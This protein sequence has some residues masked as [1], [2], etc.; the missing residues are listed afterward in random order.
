MILDSISQ[1]NLELINTLRD[2]KK[3]GTLLGILD[4]TVTPMAG[5][6]LKQWI[7]SPLIVKKDI[8]SRHN[9]IE[10]FIENKTTLYSLREILHEIKDLERIIA[11]LNCGSGNPR[12]MLSLKASCYAFP[13]IKQTIS[14][15]SDPLIVLLAK[16]IDEMEELATLLESAIRE[17]APIMIREGNIIKEGYSEELD[18]IRSIYTTG[19][20]WI[21]ELQKQEIE[22]TGIKSLKVRYNKVFGYYIEI[23]NINLSSVPDNYVRKQT[24]VNGERFITDELKEY[25]SKVL[26]AQEKAYAMEITIFNEIKNSIVCETKR[27]QEISQAIATLDT[28]ASFSLISISNDYV[29]PTINNSDE[30][31]VQGGRHPVIEHLVGKNQ[32]VPNDVELNTSDNQ[33]LIITGPNMAGKSTYIRQVALIVLMAQIG[34]YVPA[35]SA[36]IGIVDRIFTRVGASDDIA[37]GQSTFMVE[38]TETANIINNTTQKSLIILDEIGRGTSTFDGLAIAWSVCEYLH[39]NKEK[40]A[41]TLF[42]TH[43]HE[44]TELELSMSGVKNYNVAVREWEEDVIFLRKIIRGGTDK[45]YGIHVAKLAGLPKEIISRAFEILSNLEDESI[46]DSGKPALARKRSDRDIHEEEQL[47]LF[48]SKQSEYLEYLSGIDTNAI[49][50]LEALQILVEMKK[51]YKN[52]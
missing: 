9:A 17:D 39:N 5:R 37:S 30:I 52:Q 6:M 16:S 15:M 1:K 23:S 36:K 14:A 33:L 44:L 28:L 18:Q 41:R 12:D 42:A 45:S 8:D 22:R 25:E 21:A 2:G 32:Y 27:I 4:K 50:P 38:M 10:A 35:E 47:Q 7:V 48:P 11:R 49:T 29:K 46:S 40:R 34:C 3:E 31:S 43:Y 51:K 20:G 24:L 26:G 13:R 19:R